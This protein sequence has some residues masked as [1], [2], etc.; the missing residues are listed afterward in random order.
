V[1]I[2]AVTA[3]SSLK[4]LTTEIRKYSNAPATPDH[5][6]AQGIIKMA[7]KAWRHRCMRH[8]TKCA[9]ALLPVMRGNATTS[10]RVEANRPSSRKRWLNS[11]P[12]IC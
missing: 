1:V 4:E 10:R 6:L 11:K 8:V 2:K 12:S 3:C 9:G 7:G 5:T